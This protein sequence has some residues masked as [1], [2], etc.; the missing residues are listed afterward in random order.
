MMYQDKFIE[1]SALM[2]ALKNLPDPK[3]GPSVCRVAA[4]NPK[5]VTFIREPFDQI[6]NVHDVIARKVEFRDGN[7]QSSYRWKV[8][9]E[10]LVE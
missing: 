2:D 3:H 4:M 5:P 8:S 7:A 6:S 9:V 10:F 1:Q